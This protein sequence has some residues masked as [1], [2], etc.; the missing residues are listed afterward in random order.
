M[1]SREKRKVVALMAVLL[2]L[3]VSGGIFAQWRTARIARINAALSPVPTTP[4]PGSPSKEY[5]Y[6]GG[7][8]V[9]TEEP[10]VGTVPAP[11]TLAASTAST[12][13]VNLS[14]TAA[15][16]TVDHYQIERSQSGSAFTPLA[17][18]PTTPGFNDT[19]AKS[20]TAYLYRVCA[21]DAIGNHS[22][23]SNIDLAT[24]ILFTDDPLTV[25]A[26]TI[27]GQHLTELRQ[28]VNAV[29]DTAGLAAATWTDSAPFGLAIRATHIQELRTKLDEALGALNLPV[30]SYTD[31]AL[32]SA[33]TVKAVHFQ[34]LRERVK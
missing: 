30:S 24:T 3:S 11:S 31:P 10:V 29:R 6:A 34:E 4:P 17:G 20:G 5:I 25:G 19:T 16:G 27:K 18:S 33:N 15:S 21:V 26:T 9:A 13:Q 14:W 2:V 23:Y 7:R 32:S 22:T 8:L 1:S 28:A 12:S